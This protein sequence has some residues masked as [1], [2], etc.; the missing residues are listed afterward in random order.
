MKTLLEQLSCYMEDAFEKAGYDRKYGRITVSN[1]PDLCEFQCNG[2]MAA[3]KEYKKAPIMIANDVVEFIKESEVFSFAEAIA[4]GF[5]NLKLSE[6]FLAQFLADMS[7]TDKFGV[8]TNSNKR[9]LI[10]Y[11]GPNVAKPLHVGHLRSAIIGES[12]K[13]ICKFK[14]DEVIGDIHLGD[15]GLQMGLIMT[16][17]RER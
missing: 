6:K 7:E 3:A 10:D 5:L 8:N 11:G 13:R 16:E 15:W 1:R 4:P 17:L 9:V 12:V 14:G 2:A